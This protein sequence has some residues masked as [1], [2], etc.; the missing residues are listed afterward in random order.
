M[1]CVI[2]G[3]RAGLC[4][5]FWLLAPA[6]GIVDA[7]TLTIERLFAAPN[8]SGAS[9]RSPQISPDGRLV[10]YLQ[11]KPAARG[12]F[13]LWAY[14]IATRQRRM[15]VDSNLL[16]P[17]PR[18]MSAEEE[19]RRERQRSSSFRGI[20]EYYFAP[21]AERLLV[22]L[23][24]DLYVYDLSAEPNDAI[25]RITTTDAYETDARFSPGGRYVSFVRDGNLLVF[26]LQSGD[27]T[28]VTRDAG[29]TVS[30]ATAE[31][32]AQ[33]EMGR[34]TGY[35]WSPDDARI[36]YTRVD[37][38][39]VAEVKRFEIMADDVRVITQ[40]YPAAGT[41]NARVQLFVAP[42]TDPD[43]TIE[44]DPGDDPDVYLARVD[45]FPDGGTLAIQRQS[46]DQKT[47]TLLAAD[48]TTGST[49]VLLTERGT[50][51]VDIG[52]EL[53]FLEQ[54]PRFIWG[55]SRSGFRHLYLYETDGRLV[56]QLTDG[57][58][59]VV[60]TGFTPA[61]KGVDEERGRVYFMANL[62]TPL[63]R[64]F[65]FASL[66]GSEPVRLT[67]PGGWHSITLAKN[68]RVYL[69]NFSTPDRPP[70][71][72]LRTI[73]GDSLGVLVA[74]DLDAGHPYAPYLDEHLP[75]EF[76]T[77]PAAD[78]QTLHYQLIKP[79]KLVPGRRYPVIVDVYGGPVSQRVRRAWGNS[80]RSNS[81]FF[82]QFLAQHGYVVFTLDNRGTGFRGVEF[83]TALYGQ[84]GNVEVA[85]QAA[86]VEFLRSLPF[87]DPDRIGV[88]GWSYGGYMALMTV[89]QRP[90]LFAA[91]VAGAP[92]TDW[93][94]YDTHYTERYLQTPQDNPDGYA[95]SNV[96][97]YAEG[98]QGKLL[99]I[100]GMAD[101]NVLFTNS[102]TL[103]ARLQDLGKPFQT[104][105]YPGAKHGLLRFPD[106]GPHAYSLIKDFF[107]VA[108]AE[109]PAW[110]R[111]RLQR[112][113][114]DL[115]IE[116]AAA[117][118]LDYQKISYPSGD[119]LT[120]PAHLF[121]PLVPSDEPVPA[122]IYAH[123]GQHG[124]FNSRSLPRVE[125]LVRR[126]YVVLAPDYRSSS[127][128]S[129]AFYEAADYGGLEIDD[130]LAARAY[131]ARL[132]AVDPERIAILGLS[133]GGYNA[134]MAVARAPGRFAAAVDFF[135]PTDLVWRVTA[136]P[137]E[138]PNTEPGD[139]EIFAGMIG[140][141]IDDAPELY[142]ARS[143]RY[144]ADRIEEPVLILH[145]D[146]DSVVSLQESEWLAEALTAAGHQD[147]AFHVIEGGQ[148]GYP[149]PAMD[150][151]WQLAFEFLER[152]L[153]NP[154]GAL[155]V[156][157]D[158]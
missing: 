143:P 18:P 141:S 53:V 3:K 56:R 58:W 36:A 130:M 46:R 95:A 20:V 114:D 32:I 121:Q 82:Q 115:R 80:A 52:D 55:S 117:G 99:I 126:G 94:L 74:N 9:L 140:A 5:A 146:A 35:W 66:S 158:D 105:V 40:R 77:L 41:S 100:H 125:E 11:D 145:G 120:I 96:L 132:P 116:N 67:A 123:G 70:T 144:V 50:A 64:Q 142:R 150:Q 75:T 6:V 28:P 27:E 87:V 113:I 111:G 129:R 136:T 45:W 13:D 109:D 12:Q 42:L 23:G 98:L 90:D 106:T 79:R 122:V 49:R 131:L 72:T 152:V 61:I 112:Q 24:G 76:G 104:M 26:D 91:A 57:D 86:G 31:F 10:T 128:Y 78:G 38:S 54:S 147:F 151:A 83:E 107:D 37:E 63:E 119:G 149:A 84:L 137:E 8:L 85:D 93:S 43:A 138:N 2:S 34:R 71:L 19:Q 148:H 17:A 110:E 59:N 60:G 102:T 65:Y 81:G 156:D 69:D 139:R 25:R 155:G 14:D 33:E 154:A 124:Q 97:T 118:V 1:H 135:G 30:F 21:D 88:F 153:D 133:H 89:M 157:E 47:L 108:L 48:P 68:T 92:V 4:A 103:F 22:P 44:I 127:G 39:P 16:A 62:D 73:E 51:W 7:D 101:D 29:G 15:L 134:L